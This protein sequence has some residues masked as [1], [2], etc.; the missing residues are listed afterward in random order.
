MIEILNW[1]A[2]SWFRI[3]FILIIFFSVLLFLLD[4]VRMITNKTYTITEC[5][6]DVGRKYQREYESLEADGEH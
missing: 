1:F 3:L 2:D 4:T 5:I 6:D